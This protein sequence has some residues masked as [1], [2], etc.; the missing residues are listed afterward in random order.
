MTER[1]EVACQQRTIG[2]D[3]LAP[4]GQRIAIEGFG[5]GPP[6]ERLM[7]RGQA[8]AAGEGVGVVGPQRGSAPLERPLEQSNGFRGAAGSEIVVG[9]VIAAC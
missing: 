8:I 6:T 5:R 9:Q 1:D 7:G 4:A 2:P 3:E